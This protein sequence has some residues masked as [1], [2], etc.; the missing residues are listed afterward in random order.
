MNSVYS[1]VSKLNH[2][3]PQNVKKELA[4][5]MQKYMGAVTEMVHQAD[6]KTVRGRGK[7]AEKYGTEKYS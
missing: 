1:P 4:T 7:Y 2:G 5:H 3:W 6:G